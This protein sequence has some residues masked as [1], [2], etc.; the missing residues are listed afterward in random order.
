MRKNTYSGKYVILEGIDGSGKSTQLEM[1]AKF[2]QSQ[3]IPFMATSEPNRESPAYD[4]IEKFSADKNSKL[5]P[6][7]MQSLHV[8]ARNYGMVH[9]II[10]ALGSGKMVVSDRSF[11]STFA[12]GMAFGMKF[13]EIAD[14]HRE[15]LKTNWLKPDLAIL[16]D[17]SPAQAMKRITQN[18]PDTSFFEKEEKLEKIRSQ[19]L[20]LAKKKWLTVIDG[21][22]KPE[23]V[24]NQILL[25]VNKI[26]DKTRK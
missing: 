17:V 15:I 23:Q 26:L 18:R 6:L 8:Q 19:Y 13:E 4:E 14:L 9:S 16:V 22:L 1:L 20:K 25:E 3:K 5:T 24:F 21:S 2:L 11:I 7:Q 10:P 12:Y